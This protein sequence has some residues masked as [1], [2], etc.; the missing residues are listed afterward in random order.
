MN[1]AFFSGNESYWK[2][3]WENSTD[4][5]ST[6]YRTL[7][8]YK[9][10]AAQGS[11]HYN[12]QGNFQCDPDPVQ[13]TGLWREGC[14]A[15]NPGSTDGCRPEN[16]LS[17]QISWNPTV[18]DLTVPVDY[19]PLRFWRN[20]S[21]AGPPRAAQTLAPGS[22][23]YEWDP[24]QSAYASTYPAGRV[25]LSQT[26]AG[27]ADPSH[28]SLPR[29][30]RCAGLRR[31]DR[32]VGLGPRQLTMTA[33][34]RPRTRDMQQATV[35]LL[36]DMGVQPATLQSGLTAA[37]ASTDTTGPTTTITSPTA[38]S[39]VS[40]S[41]TV[42]GTATDA[43]GGVVGMVEVSTDGGTTWRPAQGRASWSYT[44]T[45]GH[46][47]ADDQ[48]ARRRRQPQHRRSRH[49]QRHRGHGHLSV[50]DL[51]PIDRRRRRRP[52]IPRRSS[53]A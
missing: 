26:D 25:L 14:P 5:S 18:G 44:F 37:S 21:I 22:L 53:L 10:G 46:R 41:V 36:A 1:L 48:G 11:E 3:R 23:G 16:A 49:G 52:T 38:G 28:E 4:A 51:E 9:E 32:P 27:R 2:T 19:A 35:N 12:C 43:G 13:W 30:Q 50:L 20:T 40:G 15:Q 24:Q 33:G 31:G 45:P 47:T 17:G 29:R 34:P 6:P 7:V 42:T 8:S 39:T